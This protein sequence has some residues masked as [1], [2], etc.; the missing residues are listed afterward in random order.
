M[1]K[2][3]EIDYILLLLKFNERITYNTRKYLETLGKI[4]TP[5]EFYTH[6]SI[7]FTKFPNNPNEKEKKIKLKSIKEINNIL[8][9]IFE[10]KKNTPL[11][12]IN[13]YFIDTEYDEIKKTYEEVFQ[14]TIDIMMEKMKLDVDIY[15][16]INTKNLDVFGNNVKIRNENYKK[17]IEKLEKLLKEEKLRKEKEEKERI[18][19]EKELEN[20]KNNQKNK[21]K[22][23]RLEELIK[24]KEEQRKKY[25]ELIKRNNEIEERR[26]IIEE[27]A[28]KKGIKI[29]KLDRFI[30]SCLIT[31]KSA[32]LFLFMFFIM[33]WRSCSFRGFSYC[34]S[35]NCF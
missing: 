2:K 20:E 6:L 8:K 33:S 31:S 28:I 14:E 7:F 21:E 16:S 11:P 22:E 19:L 27:E 25:E 10:L 26:K 32:G 13:V 30:D 34:R 17:E 15:G 18:R 12:D 5:I 9:N 4:F 3:D 35:I 23:K 24:A 1:K 29:E